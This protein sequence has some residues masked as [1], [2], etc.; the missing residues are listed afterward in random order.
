MLRS[1]S[2]AVWG[3]ESLSKSLL[4]EIFFLMNGE[5][6]HWRSLSLEPET[7]SRHRYSVSCPEVEHNGRVRHPYPFE[8]ERL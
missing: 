4:S 7:S 1:L 2:V 8:G 6:Q 3:D 5:G